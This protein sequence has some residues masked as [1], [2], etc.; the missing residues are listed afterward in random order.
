MAAFWAL[1]VIGVVVR[2]AVYKGAGFGEFADPF[3]AKTIVHS[4]I[5]I[6]AGCVAFL[7]LSRVKLPSLPAGDVVNCFSRL[8]DLS[9]WVGRISARADFGIRRWPVA[10]AIL[11][12]VVLLIGILIHLRESAG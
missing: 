6:A 11:V 7:I 5:P 8:Q 4:M 3:T 2:W 12:S 10:A 9:E 1:A